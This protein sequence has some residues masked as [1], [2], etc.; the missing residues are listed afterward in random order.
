VKCY[1]TDSIVM[2]QHFPA[3]VGLDNIKPLYEMIFKTIS[4]RVEF[5]IHEIHETASDWAWARTSSAGTQTVHA[6]GGTSKEENSELFV[7]KKTGEEWKIARY[8]FCTSNPP[9]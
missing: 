3:T 5:T 7:L 9:K 6:S 4:L 2:A 1:D 8:C